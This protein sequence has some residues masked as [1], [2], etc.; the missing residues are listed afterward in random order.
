MRE[1]R[2]A[3]KPAPASL[4]VELAAI[5]ALPVGLDRG[6]DAVACRLITRAEAMG[7]IEGESLSFDRDLLHHAVEGFAAAGIGRRTAVLGRDVDALPNALERLNEDV[8]ATPSPDTEW[9]AV[10]HILGIDATA[11]M[12]GVSVSSARRYL[13]GE[14]AT[15]DDVADRLHFLALT[16]ADLLGAYN[17]YGVRRWFERSRTS[18]GGVSPRDALGGRWTSSD[19]NAQAVSALAAGLVTMSAT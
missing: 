15:P 19:Q 14:R 3:S 10:T 11:P 18:L 7:L 2:P 5:D 12:V 13:S 17:A 9:P 4:P 8:E 1:V 16:I 6:I